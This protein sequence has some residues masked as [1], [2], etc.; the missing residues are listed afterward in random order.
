[1]CSQHEPKAI[2]IRAVE[3]KPILIFQ[4]SNSNVSRTEKYMPTI[5]SWPSEAL[6]LT[7]RSTY[8]N[9]YVECQE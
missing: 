7:K 8:P 6:P 2:T 4:S 9:K 1:M 3:L 5:I